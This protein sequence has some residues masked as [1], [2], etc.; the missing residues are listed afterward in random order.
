MRSSVAALSHSW[1]TDA[2]QRGF[3]ALFSSNLLPK[4]PR[5]FFLRVCGWQA[6]LES[7]RLYTKDI[8]PP[9]E[10]AELNPVE[11]VL[12]HVSKAQ[13]TQLYATALLGAGRVQEVWW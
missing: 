8:P 1:P 11:D 10:H 6:L 7:E 9:D 12:Q 2:L 3:A 13:V 5:F 4:L